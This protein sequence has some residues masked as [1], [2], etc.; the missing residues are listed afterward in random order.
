MF[1]IPKVALKIHD[2]EYMAQLEE[3]ANLQLYEA[4]TAAALACGDVYEADALP[5]MLQLSEVLDSNPLR[6]PY[7]GLHLPTVFIMTNRHVCLV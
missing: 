7:T 3:K 6:Y 5:V 4:V 1:V 2:R